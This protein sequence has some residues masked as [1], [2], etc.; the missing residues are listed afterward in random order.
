[1]HDEEEGSG[2]TAS[3]VGESRL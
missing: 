1:L 2:S 3:L